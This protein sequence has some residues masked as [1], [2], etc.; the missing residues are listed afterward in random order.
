MLATV[1]TSPYP[2]RLVLVFAELMFYCLA[3]YLSC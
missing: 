3:K 2:A 1:A